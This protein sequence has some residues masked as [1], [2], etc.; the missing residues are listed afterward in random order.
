[1]RGRTLIAAM[2]AL[3]SGSCAAHTAPGPQAGVDDGWYEIT[4]ENQTGN[5]LR[6]SILDGTAE[7]PIGRVGA[8][9]ERKLRLPGYVPPIIQLVAR[10][11]VGLFPERAH[12]SE[13]VAVGPGQRITWELRASPGMRD[14][15]RLSTVKVFACARDVRC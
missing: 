12:I 4:V 14:V 8:M 11:A 13:P 15:P 1:M 2:V 5:S 6:V 7:T 9:T 3:A 10:P